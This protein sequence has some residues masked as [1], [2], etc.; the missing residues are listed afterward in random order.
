MKS[1]KT[2]IIAEAGINHNGDINKAFKMI[3][4][5]KKAEADAVKFQIFIPEAVV[6]SNANMAKYAIKNMRTKKKQLDVIKKYFLSNSEHIKLMKY[7]KKKKI[8]YLCSAFDIK[9]LKFLNKKKIGTFKIPSGEITNYPYLKLLGSFRKKIILS[10]GMSHKGEIKTALKI[11]IM[12]GSKKKNITLL[13]CHTD[14]PTNPRDVNLLAMK[15][16]ERI[17][18]IKVGLSDHTLG[19]D[20]PVAAVALGA[21]VIEKHFT[22]NR[23]FKGPDHKASLLPNELIDLVKSIRKIELSLGKKEKLATKREKQNLN[24]ARKSIVAKNNIYKGEIF[25][26]H[27]ITTKRPGTGISAINWN[28]VIGKKSKKNYKMDDLIKI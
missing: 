7:C 17:F 25:N 22:L 2:Y 18:N 23:K 10:T 1:F 8:K 11:L 4:I 5:A 28:K 9:S 19:T 13:H 12:N 6:T 20:I 24:I 27:N 14:Y 15:E 3:D 16:L 26:E 21:K